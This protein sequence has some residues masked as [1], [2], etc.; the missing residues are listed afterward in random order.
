MN[1]L[2]IIGAIF[3]P[4]TRTISEAILVDLLR[5]IDTIIMNSTLKNC[6]GYNQDYNLGYLCRY[7]KDCQDY[8]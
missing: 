8:N 3:V 4:I 1:L 6:Q 7:L 2:R 5:N